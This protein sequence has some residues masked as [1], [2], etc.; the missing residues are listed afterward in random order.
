MKP[1]AFCLLLL[2]AVLFSQATDPR[3]HV[4]Q[5]GYL[6]DAQ[7]IA[8]ISSPYQGY[9][10]PNPLYPDPVYRIK[11]KSDH[12]TVFQG[13]I[14]EW[15]TGDIHSQ[16][17]DKVW[18]F[19]FSAFTE[20]GEYYLLDSFN[21]LQ[22]HPFTISDCVYDDV[23]K[24]ALRTYF[25]QR[26]GVGKSL[27]FA[28]AAWADPTPCHIGAL[29]DQACQNIQNPGAAGAKDLH[30]GWHDAGD[31]NKYVT[32][33]YGPL[34]DLLLAYEQHPA[35]WGDENGLPESGNS[36]PDLLDEVKFEL[37]WLLRMQQTDGGV[38]SV[39][40]VQNFASASPPSADHA[41]RFYG[42]A[43]TAATFSAAAAFALAARQYQQVPGLNAYA[44]QLQQAAVRAWNWGIANPNAVFY[45][46]GVIA[47]GENQTDAYETN[48]RQLASACFLFAQTG[49]NTYKTYFDAHY[50]EAHL[51]QWSYAYLFE[52]HTQEV[53]LFYSQL[54]NASNAVKNAIQNT[55]ASSI[56][57][58]NADN[59]PA[60]LNESDAYRAFIRN[61]NY[62]WGSNEFKAHQ[63]NMFFLM[64]ALGLNPANS[65][66]YRNAASGFLHY[67]HGVNPTGYCYLSNMGDHGAEFSVPSLY[68]GWFN[69]GTIWDDVQT[70][71][72]GPPPGYLPGG[73]NPYF[74]PDGS[75]NCVISPPENQPIQKSFKSWNT[76]WPE[77]SW[78]LSEVAIYT[79]A[80][81]IRLLANVLS[82]K[83]NPPDCEP[84]SSAVAGPETPR[85]RLF[86]NPAGSKL[87]LQNDGEALTFRAY[88]LLGYQVLEKKLA[89][90]QTLEVGVMELS[91][92]LYWGVW[93]DQNGRR[94][95]FETFEIVR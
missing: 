52:P 22:S 69:D 42:P 94:I 89:A 50:T 73:P 38:L 84:A 31:Y 10:G 47:A 90:R 59:L 6:P 80:A 72:F 29:Q 54:P 70:S 16:S 86:P 64:N 25:Y 34:L 46:S 95:G 40:G 51:M 74:H 67:L 49:D 92:G 39:V 82:A 58:N 26:C 75:C 62:T 68:H 33:T 79:Q 18:W 28:E 78:E 44:T 60:Y 8:V 66:H 15:N 27:P 37:D 35:L 41:Q 1:I 65:T 19:D 2:P 63:G 17:G 7:K 71:Q 55:Y 23:L 12:A 36:I 4:D 81:Y 76:G 91:P 30:G 13:A 48:M 24:Q 14:T 57:T 88:H 87:S 9:N 20:V 43:T 93:F 83:N 5:F 45:N 21:Q 77:N 61:D 85:V 11:R 3:L 32:F 56:Q 53:L